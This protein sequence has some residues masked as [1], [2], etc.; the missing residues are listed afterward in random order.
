MPYVATVECMRGPLHLVVWSILTVSAAVPAAAQ[1]SPRDLYRAL[2]ELQVNPGQIY[3]VRDLHLR[4]DVISLT[5]TEG[6][7]AFLGPLDGKITGAV[8]SGRGRVIALP[9][10]PA[11]RRSLAHFLGV[12]LLDQPVT[13]AYIRFTDGTAAD[14]SR[15][16]HEAGLAPIADPGFLESWKQI[17]SALNP[18]HSLRV[19]ASW[20]SASPLP[21][22]YA[23]FLGD[24]TGSFDVLVDDRHDE[25]VL[26]GQPRIL[27]NERFYDV[28]ASFPRAGAPAGSS[29]FFEPLDYSIDTTIA[30]DRSLQG[31]ATLRLRARCDGERMIAFELSRFLGVETATADGNPLAVFQNE[32][33]QRQDVANRGND[34]VIVFLPQPVRAGQEIHLHFTYHGS[35]IGDAGNGVYF[36]GARGAWYPH[37]VGVDQFAAFDLKFRWPR[38]LVLVSTGTL[39]DQ[40]EDGDWRVGHWRSPNPVAFAGFNLG[41]YATDSVNA[42]DPK[43]ELY[44]N[45]ALENEILSRLQARR[46]VVEQDVFPD[47]LLHHSN[48][49]RNL[50]ALEPPPPSPSAVLKQ[51][52]KNISDSIRFFEKYNGPFPFDHLAVSQ[53]PG[54]FGQGWP[55]LLYLSTFVFLPRE[56]QA[57]AGVSPRQREEFTELVPFHEVAHQWWGNTVGNGSYRDTWIQESIANYLAL[58][59]AESKR[60][61]EHIL[62]RSLEHYRT[63]LLQKVPGGSGIVEDAGPLS[64][65]FRLSSPMSPDA[66]DAILYGKGTWVIHMLR[67]MLRDS[68]AKDPDARFIELLHS[69]LT[70]FRFQPLSTAEF[71]HAVEQVMT[72]AMDVDD[73]HSLDWFFDEWVRG[74]GLPRYGVSFHVQPERTGFRVIGTLRQS[75]VPDDFTALVPLYASHPSG[76]PVYLGTVLTTGSTTSFQFVTRFA[77]RRILID[78]QLT[79]LCHTE[80]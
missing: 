62:T 29:S 72:P 31:N 27:N 58:L 18:E 16:I 67:M 59:Y 79:L 68:T 11:E 60:P 38:K 52:G 66:Y 8:F 32:A 65:G 21:Y 48:P 42:Q 25:Q 54:S 57:R 76:K 45:R 43:I 71:E 50:P 1:D 73:S 47:P 9:P 63:V 36:V 70:Q 12:P 14:L 15:Q 10:D 40:R 53:I 78:P 51:L 80:Q 22:F 19:M 46:P 6:E 34:S 28:W 56:T 37:T 55:G 33:V 17:V 5:L 44:A 23:G 39:V 35:V 7:L 75:A 41:E 74:T 64:L 20:L 26:I 30:D 2:N 77:P 61:S 49:Y 3:S 24:A 69:V 13:R 4:R